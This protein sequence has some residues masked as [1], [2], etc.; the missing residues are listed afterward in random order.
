MSA[1]ALLSLRDVGRRFAGLQAVTELAFD[2]AAH[3]ICGLIGPNGAGKST[4]FNLI[5]GELA[6]HTGQLFFSGRDISGLPSYAVARL[7]I[8]RMF[9]GVHLFESMTVAENV[10]VGADRHA[11]VD[12]VS[13][14]LHLPRQHRRE[15]A[16]LARAQKAIALLGL[17]SIAERPA[18]SIPFGQQRLVAVARA[19]AAEPALL[20]LDEPAAGLSP[21]E[22]DALAQAVRRAPAAGVTVLGVE[23]NVEFVMALCDHIVVM[24]GGRKIADGSAAEIQASAAVREAYLGS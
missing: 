21:S 8:A 16:A 24:H 7:G 15:Q 5:A 17:Q 14:C 4:T 20:L 2:I 6:P 22:I 11:P 12:L 10:L 23:P 9:Q 3:E 19:L 18:A 13:S 1:G